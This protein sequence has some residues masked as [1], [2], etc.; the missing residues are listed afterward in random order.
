[1][2]NFYWL[3]GTNNL[4]NLNPSLYYTPMT[5]WMPR[6]LLLLIHQEKTRENTN[7]NH[8]LPFE[9]QLYP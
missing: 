9:N 2:N 7:I 6:I 5:Q 3:L 4:I 8:F 1:M